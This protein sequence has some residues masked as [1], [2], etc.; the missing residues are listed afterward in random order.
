MRFPDIQLRSSQILYARQF[1][2]IILGLGYTI[3]YRTK[4]R[5]FS[6]HCTG[7]Y[8]WSNRTFGNSK[9]KN[10]VL[11]MLQVNRRNLLCTNWFPLIYTPT[12]ACGTKRGYRDTSFQD[13]IRLCQHRQPTQIFRTHPACW[14]APNA[15]KSI[16]T[17]TMKDDLQNDL[18]TTSFCPHKNFDFAHK[19]KKNWKKSSPNKLSRRW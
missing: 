15:L 2:C 3:W 16:L 1:W 9:H 13:V 17:I 10:T 14:N 5:P 6:N 4:I 11:L 8:L 19:M 7:G 18:E 12:E